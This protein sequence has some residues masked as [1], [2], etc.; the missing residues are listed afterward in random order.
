MMTRRDFPLMR[1]CT[2]HAFAPDRWTRNPKPGSAGRT[3]SR[4]GAAGFVPPP[5]PLQVDQKRGV[6]RY[7][8]RHGFSGAASASCAA[9]RPSSAASLR[10]GNRSNAASMPAAVR[11]SGGQ[12]AR[13]ITFEKESS[14]DRRALR[15][16]S[17]AWTAIMC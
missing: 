10:T 7:S 13:L 16:R 11:G 12:M 4:S 15:N 17:Y 5:L 3:S 2:M 9:S 14:G 6:E 8:V 1:V